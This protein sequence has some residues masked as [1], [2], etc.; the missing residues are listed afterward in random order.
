[1]Y[2]IDYWI[3]ES[4]SDAKFGSNVGGGGFRV[5]RKLLDWI[6]ICIANWALVWAVSQEVV[7]ISFNLK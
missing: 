6:I 5:E 2:C 3:S 4:D 1:L 7:L